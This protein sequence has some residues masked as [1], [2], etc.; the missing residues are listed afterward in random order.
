MFLIQ[1]EIS[2]ARVIALTLSLETALV[3]LEDNLFDEEI[4]S[5][6]S[7]LY[8]LV[9]LY[10]LEYLYYNDLAKLY[11]VYRETRT[12]VSIISEYPTLISIHLFRVGMLLL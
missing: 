10:T 1:M 8:V 11:R 2:L 5:F 6:N 7:M 9:L 4:N 12:S 3:V